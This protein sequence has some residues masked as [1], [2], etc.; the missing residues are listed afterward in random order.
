MVV[1]RIVDRAFTMEIK[2]PKLASILDKLNKSVNGVKDE[3]LD[4]KD[5]SFPVK[6]VD[7]ETKVSL[8][9]QLVVGAFQEAGYIKNDKQK[10]A[11]LSFFGLVK[12]A[13]L[14][15]NVVSELK[16]AGNGQVL[17]E[18]GKLRFELQLGM[19]TYCSTA[20]KGW[21]YKDSWHD[22]L[23]GIGT[24]ARDITSILYLAGVE[25]FNENIL[26]GWTAC[27]GPYM[28]GF[29]YNEENIPLPLRKAVRGVVRQ[30]LEGATFLFSHYQSVACFD[31]KCARE[32][33]TIWGV[34]SRVDF[35]EE[36][37][38]KKIEAG[39]KNEVHEYKFAGNCYVG[40]WD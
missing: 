25:K 32:G 1:K 27:G 12:R 26:P 20:S 29:T 28:T 33:D 36:P 11:M 31:D 18:H 37:Y 19:K 13:R 40:Q 7:E 21:R 24:L 8:M 10:E 5:F 16:K 3:V 14:F 35:S 22:S 9:R 34:S 38:L 39:T 2:D 30:Y 15:S 4:L 6:G 17:Q 23:M